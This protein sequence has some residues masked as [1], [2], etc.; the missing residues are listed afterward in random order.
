MTT[1]RKFRNVDPPGRRIISVTVK[2]EVD[3]DADLSFIGEYCN[4]G[5]DFCIDRQE[6]GDMDRGQYRYFNPGSVEP[7]DVKASW[8]PAKITDPKKREAYW[9]K[10]MKKN[11]E[12]DYKMMEA[13]NRSEWYMTGTWAEATIVLSGTTTQKIESGGLWGTESNS[14]KDYFKEIEDEQL[15][16]LS[17]QLLACGFTEK[18]IAA[19]FKNLE[20]EID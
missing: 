19:A 17:D 13:Y 10:A 12:A 7:F 1:T 5:G 18:E 14:E 11:A 9:F 16:E 2:R 3:T 15:E 20:R 4:V 8:I 6:R